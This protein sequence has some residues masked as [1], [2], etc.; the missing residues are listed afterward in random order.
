MSVSWW[1]HVRDRKIKSVTERSGAKTAAW[2]ANGPTVVNPRAR[3]AYRSGAEN[4]ATPFRA[5]IASSFFLV[6]LAASLLFGGHAAIDPIL[7][8]AT[9]ARGDSPAA[10]LVYSMPD[11]QFCRHMSYDNTTSELVE[12]GVERCPDGVARHEFRGA[13]GFAWGGR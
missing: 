12:G 6:L 13:G 5:I 9:A 11:G 4:G 3:N 1:H 8:M 2:F 7:R 10:D